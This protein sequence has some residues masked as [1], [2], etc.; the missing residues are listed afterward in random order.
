VDACECYATLLGEVAESCRSRALAFLTAR[1]RRRKAQAFHSLEQFGFK[2]VDSIQ[3]FSL[4]LGAWRPETTQVQDA[5]VRPFELSDLED[6]LEIAGSSYICD[7]FHSDPVIRC[8]TANALH[9]AWLRNSCAGIG[10]E[11]VMVGADERGVT[12][13]VTCQIDRRQREATGL[14]VGTIVMVATAARVRGQG[15]ALAVTFGALEWFRQQEVQVV[16]VGTQ[17]RNLGAA[18]LYQKAGFR[19]TGASFTFRKLLA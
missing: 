9:R 7:R 15:W 14:A 11:Q 5:R 16:V 6:V 12:S 17:L 1:V 19:P 10:C 3:T 18:S 8:E 4:D 13:Y 2:L